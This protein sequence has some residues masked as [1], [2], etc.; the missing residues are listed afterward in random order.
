MSIILQ[1]TAA[2]VMVSNPIRVLLVEDNEGDARL[3]QELLAEVGDKQFTL[4]F[5]T[6]LSSALRR[7]IKDPFDA[8]LL[9]LSLVDTHGLPT[10]LEVQ[11][12]F[13]M[14]PI[15][16]LSGLDRES[17]AI[18]T[19]R[20]GAQDYLVKGQAGGDVLARAIRNAI[21][22]KRKEMQLT[23]SIRDLEYSN[24]ELAQA[25][26]QALEAA[27]IKSEFL[28]KL[29][30]EMRTPMNGV[31]G[32]TNLLLDS[33]LTP[34]QHESTKTIQKSGESL[35]SII[36]RIFNVSTIEANHPLLD[37]IDFDLRVVVEE[38]L[39]V[40]V[41]QASRKDLELVGLVS[42]SVPTIL[43]GDP[44]RLRQILTNLIGNAVKYTDRGE[45]AI[46]VTLAAL[47]TEQ[48]CIRFEIRDTGNG[49]TPQQQTDL[50]NTFN[51]TDGSTKRTQR[52]IGL[53]LAISKRL[54][55]NM[56]GEIGIESTVGKGS[57]FWFT[58]HLSVQPRMTSSKNLSRT[59][60][61][62][63][64]VCL[65]DDNLL[66]RT[67]LQHHATRWGMHYVGAE[68]GLEALTIMREAAKRNRGFDLSIV[69]MVMPGMTGFE[70]ARAI[71]ADPMLNGIR[72]VLL[73]SFG[74]RGDAKLAREAGF[75]AYLTKPICHTQL[76]ECLCM[77]MA[78]ATSNKPA[79]SPAIGLPLITSH[80]LN[81]AQARSRAR[82]LVAEHD[83]I[84]QKVLAQILEKLGLRV[85]VVGNGREAVEALKRQSY[86]LVFMDYRM[87]EMD[88]FQATRCIREFEG[89]LRTAAQRP[90][91]IPIIALSSDMQLADQ[92]RCLESGMDGYLSKPVKREEMEN[93]V[94]Q[95]IPRQTSARIV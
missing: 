61:Q 87:P 35:L 27:H 58:L 30:H 43:R 75:M 47:T 17:L 25:R 82:I 37:V 69:D 66:S 48:A 3:T 22:R 51:L 32:M 65:V 13:P 60:L 50:F 19:L 2:T 56:G 7:L 72:L 70:L 12:A 8:V 1:E 40:L 92:A 90:P 4:D 46:H 62:G 18:E 20:H 91:R 21:E 26:D 74:R 16:V 63:F 28:V 44:G 57:L 84:S 73:T 42:A 31:M 55:E 78:V 76:Y 29:S 85:D 86:A 36:N 71:Q 39:D 24:R 5:V 59:D 94:H 81:E 33:A 53:G 89:E 41:I 49:L 45:V 83:P 6:R 23:Q 80:S 10:L 88:G 15:V 67:L 79:S 54:V 64:H 9:D 77:V 38:V 93:I 52:G 14:M 11:S 68:S 34:D 95:W